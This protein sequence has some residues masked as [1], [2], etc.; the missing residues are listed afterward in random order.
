MT[1]AQG[2]NGD[3]TIRWTTELGRLPTSCRARALALVRERRLGRP[4]RT[5]SDRDVVKFRI[6]C[7][8]TPDEPAN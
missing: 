3:L 6:T 7:K 4:R 8:V 5:I 2:T 1:D